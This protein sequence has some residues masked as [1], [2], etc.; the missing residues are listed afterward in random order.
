M[1]DHALI[2]LITDT[3]HELLTLNCVLDILTLYVYYPIEPSLQPTMGV[4]TVSILQT[5]N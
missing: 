2:T 3:D 4:I 1:A 5:S